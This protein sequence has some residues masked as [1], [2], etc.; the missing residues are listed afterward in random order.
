[1]SAGDLAGATSQ[2]NAGHKKLQN[3]TF[4]GNTTNVNE[5][6]EDGLGGDEDGDDDDDEEDGEEEDIN[7]KSE[8]LIVSEPNSF[9]KSD[10]FFLCFITVNF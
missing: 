6:D 10:I 1:M 7:I 2:G 8:D 9:Q 5:S 4:S 3:K